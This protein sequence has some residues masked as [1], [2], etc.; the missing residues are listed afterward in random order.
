MEL[1]FQSTVDV[2]VGKRV[3]KKYF[4]NSVR[5]AH[6]LKAFWSDNCH[7]DPISMSPGSSIIA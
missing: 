4:A 2:L 6:Y 1:C 7:C 3:G 5:L